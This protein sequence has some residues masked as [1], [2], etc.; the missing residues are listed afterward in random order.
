MYNASVC[1]CISHIDI[2]VF[3]CLVKRSVQ[4]VD[5]YFCWV[6]F[7]LGHE[8]KI[9]AIDSLTRERAVTCGGRD[10]SVRIWKVLE[11]SQLVFHGHM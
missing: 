9:T 11:E 2:F 10:R 4:V 7:R 3:S 8:D 5:S 6:L 1:M